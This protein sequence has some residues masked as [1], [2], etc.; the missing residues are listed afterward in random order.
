MAVCRK[1]NIC[2]SCPQVYEVVPCQSDCN[3]YVWVAEPWSV[4]KVSNV[5]LKENCGEGV[6]TRKVRCMLNTVDGPSEAVED[7]L[8]DPE[9]MPLGARESRLPCPEDCV[10][11]DWGPWSRCSLPCTR[12]NSRVRTAYTIRSP[13]VGRECPDTTDKEACSLNLNCFNYFYN[14]T[15]TGSCFCLW[16]FEQR[17]PVE[18]KM[19]NSYM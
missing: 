10:L 1:V 12:T 14:I 4:W 18:G 8:C 13:S 7:Y 5:D 19:E 2:G 3:Q 17:K 6:Q 16:L 15:G 9:E 11:N